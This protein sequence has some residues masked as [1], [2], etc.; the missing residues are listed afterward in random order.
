MNAALSIILTIVSITASALITIWYVQRNKIAHFLTDSY[1]I[2][3]GLANEF[4][5]F[6]LT[7]KGEN[8]SNIVYVLKGGF[9]NVGLNDIDG[10]NGIEDISMILPEGCNVWEVKTIPSNNKLVVN[11]DF[12][13]NVINFGIKNS[14]NKEGLLKKDDFFWYVAIVESKEKIWSWGR[15]LKFD[16]RIKNTK[17]EITYN[18]INLGVLEGSRKYKILFFS[19]TSF[20]YFSW[21]FIMATHCYSLDALV[22]FW[23]IVGSSVIILSLL[24]YLYFSHYFAR[25]RY[26]RHIKKVLLKSM[27]KK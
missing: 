20:L 27:K 10:L 4:P 3:K 2:G 26:Y 15:S 8:M 9:M 22:L 7:Y 5:E 18:R 23:I 13:D 11:K 17:K 14:L 16:H 1:D 19:L 21:A 25:F 6:K 12:K 24:A